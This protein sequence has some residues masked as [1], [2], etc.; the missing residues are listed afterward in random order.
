MSNILTTTIEAQPEFPAQDLTDSNAE[1]LELM[2]ASLEIVQQMHHAAEQREW[3]YSVEHPSILA[4]TSRLYEGSFVGAVGHGV[5][6]FEAIHTAV[7]GQSASRD[8]L[9]VNQKATRLFNGSLR[10]NELSDDMIRAVDNFKESMPRTCEVV[11]SASERFI[12]SYLTAYAVLG[13]AL[14][15]EIALDEITLS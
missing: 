3:S 9:V 10:E 11:A 7:V 13:A 6:V 8:M 2:M 15:R 5:T 4:G 12:G 14:E 1:S